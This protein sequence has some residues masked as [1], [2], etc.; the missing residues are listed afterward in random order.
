M[1]ERTVLLDPTPTA[2]VPVRTLTSLARGLLRTTR[3]AS[4]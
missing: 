3:P 4:G 1:A 2:P